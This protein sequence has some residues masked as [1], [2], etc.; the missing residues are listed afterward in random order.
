MKTAKLIF[1]DVDL[2]NKNANNSIRKII[3]EDLSEITKELSAIGHCEL[4]NAVMTGGYNKETSH[5]IFVPVTDSEN[6]G[7]RIN[8]PSLHQAIRS[9]LTLAKLY[10]IKDI[11]VELPLWEEEKTIYNLR[12]WG[13]LLKKDD[14]TPS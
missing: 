7:N 10:E 1:S 4:G 11:M 2:T 13:I 3:D 6:V 5:T 9:A 14:Q 12:S 8:L